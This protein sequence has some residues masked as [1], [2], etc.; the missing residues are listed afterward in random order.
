MRSKTEFL[1]FVILTAFVLISASTWFTGCATAP[2][3]KEMTPEQKQAYEDS[4]LRVYKRQMALKWSLGYEPYK[5]KDYPRAKKYFKEVAELDT[6][7]TYGK[8]LYQRLG[9]CYL[10]MNQPDSAEWAYLIGVERLPDNAYFYK[11]LAYIYRRDNRI[12]DAIEMY[13]TLTTLEADSA[14]N[15]KTLGELYVRN[16][17]KESAIESYQQAMELD[18]AD[19][20][21]KE[22][23]DNLVGSTEERIALRESMVEQTPD[24][25]S[26]RLDLAKLYYQIA[27]YEKAVAQLVVVTEKEPDNLEAL[28]YLGQSYQELEKF[29]AAATAFKKILA[30]KPDDKKNICNL[31]IAMASQGQFTAALGQVN[32]ALSIDANFGLAYIA[33][34]MAYE[35]AAERCV[36][37]NDGKVTFD[38]KLVYQKASNEYKNAAAKDP[39]W[40]SEANRRNTYVKTMV[41][42]SSDKFMH[43]GQASPEGPCY[44]WIQ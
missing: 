22:I 1:V 13:T 23:L 9:D 12:D 35:T 21:T 36:D 18:P 28:E 44:T 43:K 7:G 26:K 38:D 16:D 25:M 11:V 27:E 5:Q 33:R 3:Q 2:V 40:A 19:M 42:T 15:W 10:Q 6:I 37:Q 8:V 24:D 39:V 20:Q 29:T 32:K 34:G 31:A 4:L 17:D 30:A 14:N 41:P